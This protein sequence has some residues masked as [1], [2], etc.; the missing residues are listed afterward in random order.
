[1]SNLPIAIAAAHAPEITIFCEEKSAFFNFKALINHAKTTI[2]VPCW[3]SWN[4]G[5]FN[6]FFNSSSM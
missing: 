4:T 5:I 3:S 1:L 6:F 2:A